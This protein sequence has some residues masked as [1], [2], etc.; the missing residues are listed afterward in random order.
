MDGNGLS[1][2]V[3]H[4]GPIEHAHIALKPLTVFVGRN[5][6]GK[7]YA[8]QALYAT[9][10]ALL[11]VPPAFVEEIEPQERSALD[12]LLRKRRSV[13]VG[14]GDGVDDQIPPILLETFA[15]VISESLERSGHALELRLK[16]SFGVEN[17]RQIST[18]ESSDS[19][20][21]ELRRSLSAGPDFALFGSRGT[22][23]PVQAALRQ[24]ELPW[25]EIDSYLP[26]Q[27]S[28]FRD[29]DPRSEEREE[30]L[31]A[32]M[33]VLVSEFWD[34][35]SSDWGLTGTSHYLPAGRSGLLNAWTDVVKL[36]IQLERDRF[37]LPSIP[38]PSLDG[39]ALDF[40]S[41]LADVLGSRSGRARH[42]RRP[43]ETVVR[44]GHAEFEGVLKLLSSVMEGRITVEPQKTQVP[45]LAYQQSGQSIA[46]RHASSM[47]AD[48]APLAIWVDRLLQPGDLLIVDEPESHL[49]PEAI[50]VVARVLVRL[51][52]SGVRIVCATH[53]SVLLHELSN[54][55]LRDAV[56]ELPDEDRAAGYLAEDRL[57]VGDL[58]VH[59]FV[60]STGS[61]TVQVEQ[62][63][64]EPE[65]GI[66]EDEYVK[67]AADLSDDSARLVAQ[68]K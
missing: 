58:A 52:N 45:T 60:R 57:S 42:R 18:W 27:E 34:R 9:R 43:W 35:V 33:W 48:L 40:I 10:Q 63:K 51:V 37:G 41:S 59:R 36:R 5:N 38:E 49:H 29:D 66:P 8:A 13:A 24:T 47:V 61:G 65:W 67:V 25:T 19:L 55:V 30:R 31:H 32:L 4:L 6:T 53:S 56:S 54:A 64:V 15:R 22:N 68:L 44:G 50:R 14:N 11:A 26:L 20:A 62:L 16:A 7:T 23:A 2:V 1:L 28:L 46:I 3:D 12:D 21:V 17:L 39:V